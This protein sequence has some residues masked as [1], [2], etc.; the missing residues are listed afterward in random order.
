LSTV[1]A[2]AS[3]SSASAVDS[4]RNNHTSNNHNPNSLLN[5]DK[6]HWSESRQSSQEERQSNSHSSKFKTYSKGKRKHVSSS[7]THSTGNI[8]VKRDDISSDDE[9]SSSEDVSSS[10]DF[11]VPAKWRLG[12][13]IM[14]GKR[15]SL[16]LVSFYMPTAHKDKILKTHQRTEFYEKE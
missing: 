1:A 12:Q 6:S 5:H 11:Q 7:W 15:D 4:V 2:A 8:K 13:V 10:L 14:H 16:S 3:S 9:T